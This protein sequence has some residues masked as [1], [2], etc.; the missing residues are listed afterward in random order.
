LR[1]SAYLVKAGIVLA[2]YFL[3]RR[4]D[5]PDRSIEAVQPVATCHTVEDTARMESGRLV[6]WNPLYRTEPARR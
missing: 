5:D 3:L 1:P 6:I 4:S 2:A